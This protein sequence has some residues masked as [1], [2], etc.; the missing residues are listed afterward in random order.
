MH[1]KINKIIW[2]VVVI[3]VLFLIFYI[4]YNKNNTYKEYKTTFN[5]MDTNIEVRIYSKDKNLALK[6]LKEVEKIF[7]KYH[8][9]TD[10][11][12]AYDGIN[13]IYYIHNNTSSDEYIKLDK[14]LFDLIEYAKGYTQKTDGLVDIKMG[15]VLDL[16][17][18]YRTLNMGVPSYEELRLASSYDKEIILKD[19][20]LIYNNH[21]NIDLGSIA[22]GYTTKVVANYLESKGVN[23]YLINAG[24]NVVVGDYYNKKG[25]YKIGIQ[26]PKSNGI[27]KVIKGNN[28][29]VVTSGS[30]ERYYEYNGKIYSHIIN[31]KTLYPENNFLSVTVIC[32]DSALA[33]IL[34]TYLF[35]I[36]VDSGI[37]Y[38]E[39]LDGV[40]A[41]WYIDEGN[42]KK[43]SGVVFYE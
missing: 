43:T 40:E 16:W 22:K 39:N 27:F 26:D 2:S 28:I 33:D 19:D 20:N 42:V 4:I 5:Y 15:N 7:D 12:N 24:G 11:Y 36:D 3:C 35:L 1:S 10:K 18:Q 34:S 17:H 41:I 14:E 31:P 37:K 25:E 6:K 29:S 21:V 9:L 30:Y 38:I 8:K 32:N 13:N 23:R